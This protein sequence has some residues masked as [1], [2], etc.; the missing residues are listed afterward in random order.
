MDMSEL[1]HLGLLET[2]EPPFGSYRYLI[3]RRPANPKYKV[4]DVC[5][6][7]VKGNPHIQAE[8]R[9]FNREE[10]WTRYNCHELLSGHEN[11]LRRFRNESVY[12]VQTL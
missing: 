4:C 7:L 9:Y 2:L 6:R 10:G 12:A 11:C 8:E 3:G 5:S 1:G